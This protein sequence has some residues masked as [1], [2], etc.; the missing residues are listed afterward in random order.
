MS[1]ISTILAQFE[2][3]IRNYEQNLKDKLLANGVSEDILLNVFQIEGQVG[4]DPEEG[5]SV[6]TKRFLAPNKQTAGYG[7]NI[8]TPKFSANTTY[9][10]I[11]THSQYPI[12]EK[13]PQDFSDGR[14]ILVLNYVSSPDKPS[15]SHALFADFS[16]TYIKFKD[17]FLKNSDLMSYNPSLLFGPGWIV[18]N[19]NRVGEVRKALTSAGI[20]YRE[21]EFAEYFDE[22]R[23]PKP[24]KPISVPTTAPKVIE[25]KPDVVKSVKS[26]ALAVATSDVKEVSSSS[27]EEPKPEPSKPAAV[28][29]EPIIQKPKEIP[30]KKA[31]PHEL[32]ER[33]VKKNKFGNYEESGTGTIFMKLPVG[34]DGKPVK[35]ALGYQNPSLTEKGLASVS[36]FDLELEKACKSLGHTILTLDIIQIVK[37]KDDALGCKLLEMWN[38]DE[39]DETSDDPDNG[40]ESS[41]NS[42]DS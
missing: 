1:T 2:E 23:N 11:E 12:R 42:D 10:P 30:E 34:K 40:D 9:K 35:I 37:K 28:N 27:E 15:F 26:T 6:P 41:E 36:R 16:K 32:I 5:E 25:P 29:H 7:G 22:V 13:F 14:V 24:Q 33:T 21:V 17:T 20:K 39:I 38:R 31:P 3:V 8:I 18:K 4:C 19:K